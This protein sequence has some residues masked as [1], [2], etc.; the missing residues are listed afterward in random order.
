MLLLLMLTAAP[1]EVHYIVKEERTS[2]QPIE[3][4]DVERAIGQ[5]ALEALT[6]QGA[7]KLVPITE[8]QAKQTPPPYLLRVSGRMLDEAETHSVYLS[9][10]PRSDS[11]IGSLRSSHTAPI[12]KQTKATMLDKI[13][14]SAKSAASDLWNGLSAAVSRIGKATP[15]PPLTGELPALPW[16]WTEVVTPK[17]GSLRAADDLYAKA[18]ATRKAALRELQSLALSK[19]APRNALEACALKHPDKDIRLGCL[20]ALRPLSRDSLPTQ[21]VVTEVF[22]KDN[23]RRIVQEASEQMHYFV[24][25]SQADAIAAWLDR[26]SRA[27]VYGPMSELGDQPNLDLAIAKCFVAAG[28]RPKYQRSKA[29]CIEMLTPV[30]YE[31]R[32]AILWPLL[33]EGNPDSPRFLE[34]AGQ[35]EGSTGTDWQ[36][37]VE[38]LLEEAPRFPE[39]LEDVLWRRYERTLSSSS[40]SILAAWAEPNERLAKRF[41]EVVQTGGGRAAVSGLSRFVTESEPLRPMI[42]E[43][44]AELIATEQF[45]KSISKKELETLLK[46]AKGEKR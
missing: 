2:W 15:P 33:T 23:E 17:V 34:G 30:P 45:H 9:F 8:K 31:R 36:R 28:K 10:E 6:K 44:V 40:L 14:H 29:Q 32:F 19:Q 12:G 25:L 42:A 20:I 37:A 3:P 22:R 5:A 21:R 4:D 16:K 24:G 46:R 39:G 27:E 38:A 11:D 43:G 35:H 13:E 1:L 18:S 26:A 7:I 41:L